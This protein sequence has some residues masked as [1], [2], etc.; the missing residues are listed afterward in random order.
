MTGQNKIKRK[1]RQISH[2]LTVKMPTLIYTINFVCT[3]TENKIFMK[4]AIR[5]YILYRLR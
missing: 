1:K 3:Q 4:F 5:L 2:L